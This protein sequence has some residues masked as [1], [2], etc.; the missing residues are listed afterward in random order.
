M[1][2]K[3][4]VYKD[5][6]IKQDSSNDILNRPHYGKIQP[7]LKTVLNKVSDHVK[8]LAQKID[9]PSRVKKEQEKCF[10]YDDSNM[11]NQTYGLISYLIWTQNTIQ[12]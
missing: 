3:R 5:K 11:I 1:Y 2:Q 4:L 6:D 10:L 7:N 9:N 12:T 8:D